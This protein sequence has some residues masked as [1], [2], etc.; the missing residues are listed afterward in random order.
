MGR[1][2][3]R[4]VPGVPRLRLSLPLECKRGGSQ[5]TVEQAGWS[6]VPNVGSE[7]LAE[8]VGM[9]IELPCRVS[10]TSATTAPAG[11]N[12]KA[13]P[14]SCTTTAAKPEPRLRRSDKSAR[15]RPWLLVA[16]ARKAS[17]TAS[18]SIEKPAQIERMNANDELCK[19]QFLLS[20]RAASCTIADDH[21]GK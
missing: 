19:S 1:A 7:L 10:R 14:T 15:C 21:P 6:Q 8:I 13:R 12:R 18:R 11:V 17:W 20:I 5:Q 4:V 9:A 3:N 16:Q 2:D